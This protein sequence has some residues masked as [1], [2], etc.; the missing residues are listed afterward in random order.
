MPETELHHP[1]GERAPAVAE[2]VLAVVAQ[3]SAS[4]HPVTVDA[5]LQHDL[6]IFSLALTQVLVQLEEE[7]GSSLDDAAV[8]TAELTTVGDLIALMSGRVPAGEPA[9]TPRPRS[10]SDQVQ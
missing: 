9:P 4:D 8:A 7:L 3:A 6:G 10:S 5:R 2:T 1:Q